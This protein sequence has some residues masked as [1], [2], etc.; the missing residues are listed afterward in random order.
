MSGKEV[1]DGVQLELLRG[2]AGQHDSAHM[3]MWKR[4]Q[5][6]MRKGEVKRMGDSIK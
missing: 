3:V 4:E 5:N 6:E 2:T 1:A